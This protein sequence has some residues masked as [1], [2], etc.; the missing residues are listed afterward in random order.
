MDPAF[1]EASSQLA[2]TCAKLKAIVAAQSGR[3]PQLDARNGGTMGEIPTSLTASSQISTAFVTDAYVR[4]ALSA[5]RDDLLRTLREQVAALDAEL[6]KLGAGLEN[7]VS[8]A[9]QEQ[10]EAKKLQQEIAETQDKFEMIQSARETEAELEHAV[11]E[12]SAELQRL[13]RSVREELRSSQFGVLNKENSVSNHA[14]V[15]QAELLK[16]LSVQAVPDHGNPIQAVQEE[17][18]AAMAE[19]EEMFRHQ[20]PETQRRSQE[21]QLATSR[22]DSLVRSCSPSF[23]RLNDPDVLAN[24]KTALHDAAAEASTPAQVIKIAQSHLQLRDLERLKVLVGPDL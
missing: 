18:T 7:S 3:L 6:T 11:R 19:M 1:A 14:C 17:L 9:V 15:R 2:Q 24:W 10:R 4:K 16:S 20:E 12:S 5:Y 22:L 21:L 8:E 23:D 13:G